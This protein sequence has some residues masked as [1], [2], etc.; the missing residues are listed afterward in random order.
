MNWGGV[1]WTHCER[2]EQVLVSGEVEAAGLIG[3]WLS[4]V[5]ARDSLVVVFWGN[6]A[7]PAVA[8]ASS[9]AA[10]H[11]QDILYTSDDLWLF[12]VD[13]SVLIEYLHDGRLT[14][15]RVPD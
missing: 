8:M 9:S 6:M 3:T 5:S 4:E 7:V 13:E 1:D 2:P 10:A 15:G 11:A 12:A 14:M